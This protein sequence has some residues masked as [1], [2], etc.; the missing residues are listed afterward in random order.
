MFSVAISTLLGI[1]QC[2]I[3][4]GFT[5][6]DLTYQLR[7]PMLVYEHGVKLFPKILY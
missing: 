3:S 6:Y 2:I 4:C 7:A 1:F 5:H